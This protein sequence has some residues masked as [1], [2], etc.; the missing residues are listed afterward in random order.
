MQRTQEL[1]EAL[2]ALDEI[3]Q[4]FE[5]AAQASDSGILD[6][7]LATKKLYCSRRWYEMLGRSETREPQSGAE[8]LKLVHADDR[9]NA[10]QML[11]GHYE[12]QSADFSAEVRMLHADGT[13]RWMLSRGMAVR[14][15]T[16]RP[17]RMVGSQTDI[18]EIK[19]L[20]EALRN[21]SIRDGLSGLYN[22]K[23][24]AERLSSAVQ[25]ATRHDR[26]L[27]L[28]MCDLDGLKQINDVYGHQAGDNVIRSLSSAITAEIR[29][30]DVAARYGGDKFCIML[31]ETG[32]IYAAACLERIRARVESMLFFTIDDRR[33]AVTASFGVSDLSG[34]SSS[35]LIE[36]ADH[37]LYEAKKRGGNRIVVEEPTSTSLLN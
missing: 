33:Y 11:L 27:S 26:P 3:R 5:L 15:A 8:F 25:A 18:T 4:R 22:R 17:V 2:S 13:Y 24:F 37:A 32:A 21:E 30:E 19:R 16:G 23:H 6:L 36:A 20:Q 29:N 28:C 7:D 35:Q 34:R 1:S 31:S 9:D 10:M 12:G 14:D